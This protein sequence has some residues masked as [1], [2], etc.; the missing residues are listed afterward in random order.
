[1]SWKEE[2]DER[3]SFLC[4]IVICLFVKMHESGLI[5]VAED[6]AMGLL[7]KE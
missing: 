7:G 2:P 5:K 6:E 4:S 3:A 1:L